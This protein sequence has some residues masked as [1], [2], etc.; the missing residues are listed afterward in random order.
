MV[1]LVIFS[2][3][4]ALTI[5]LHATQLPRETGWGAVDGAGAVISAGDQ[6][7]TL[8]PALRPGWSFKVVSQ[9]S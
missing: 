3:I 8:L 9:L 5:A 1:S 6:E 7:V 2:I 4:L